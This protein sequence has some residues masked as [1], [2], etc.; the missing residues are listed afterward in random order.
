VQNVS[1][2][3]HSDDADQN[4]K[5]VQNNVGGVALARGAPRQDDGIRGIEEPDKHERTLR[6][7]PTDQAETE[8]PHEHANHFD[9]FKVAT[10]KYI[11]GGIFVETGRKGEEMFA[12]KA[13]SIIQSEE[14]PAAARRP[15]QIGLKILCD[16]AFSSFLFPQASLVFSS[17]RHEGK[18]VSGK[19]WL[20]TLLSNYEKR[21]KEKRERIHTQEDHGRIHRP[22]DFAA[23]E[24]AASPGQGRAMRYLR[25]TEDDGLALPQAR[26]RQ[27][28]MGAE[29]FRLGPPEQDFDLQT[30][31]GGQGQ[32]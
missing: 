17:R 25:G 4:P 30:G 8:N 20:L 14:P 5:R 12:A 9:G 16:S 27:S 26:H 3:Q 19:Q 7:E 32:G 10:D 29:V 11:H 24:V 23:A 1:G 2:T 22:G 13:A 18:R 15:R 6:P 21:T 31:H 28:R